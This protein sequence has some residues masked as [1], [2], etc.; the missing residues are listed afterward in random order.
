MSELVVLTPGSF[1]CGACPAGYAGN[2]VQCEDINECLLTMAVVLS[3]RQFN[4]SMSRVLLV[5]A[6]VRLAMKEMAFT[7]SPLL[8]VSSTMAAVTHKQTV[9]TRQS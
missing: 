9:Q 1:Y 3:P 7:A 4:A 5:V 8:P 2:G 6:R